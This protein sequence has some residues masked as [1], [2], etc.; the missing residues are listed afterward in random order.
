MVISGG[1]L[2]SP[3]PARCRSSRVGTSFT[4]LPW[5]IT[6]TRSQIRRSSSSSETST[7]PAP[8]SA[9]SS[10]A[11][12]RDCLAFTSTPAVGL[13]DHERPAGRRPA[14]GRTRPSA[15]CRRTG[16]PPAGRG[17]SVLMSSRSII[18]R[19]ALAA[20][21]RGDRAE[22]AELARRSGWWR[23]R[24]PTAAGR[25][26][27]GAGPGARSRDPRRARPARL[28]AVTTVPLTVTVP[29]S[30]LRQA[31]QGL[32]QRDLAAAAGAGQADDLPGPDGQ[33]HVLVAAVES[34]PLGGEHHGGRGVGRTGSVFVGRR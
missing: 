15:R 18:R 20:A 3:P 8:R 30:A 27:R 28:P 33:V 7:A 6:R 29:V 11:P 24:R 32:R 12:S 17:R 19:A 5:N 26:P 16:P 22:P 25:S 21:G 31:D 4:I 10:T 2:P 34:E 9:A 23:S 1:Y 14:P 13:I